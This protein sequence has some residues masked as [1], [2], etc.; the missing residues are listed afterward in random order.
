[1]RR[2]ILEFIA[3]WISP[4]VTRINVMRY[5]FAGQKPWG[6][7]YFVFRQRVI[8]NNLYSE[9][10]LN[11]FKN[12][13]GFA[14]YGAGLDERVVEYPWLFSHFSSE[15]KK[16]LDAG[17]TFNF[18][19]IL[20]HPLLEE[21]DI[22]IFTLA[23]ERQCFWY[24]GVS[25]HYG[26]LRKMPFQ[27]SWFDEVVCIS[28]LEHVGMD[29]RNYGGGTSELEQMDFVM[30]VNELIRVL[31]PGGNIYITVP[32]GQLQYVKWGDT[33]FM[34]QFNASL[35]NQLVD[36]QPNVTFDVTYYQYDA[37]GWR[38]SNSASADDAT[39]FNIHE[40]KEIDADRAAAARAIACLVGK[41]SED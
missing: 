40:A 9:K 22:T 17:S 6:P 16:L 21:R 4:I 29:N 23:P 41:K 12:N 28:T 11:Q 27:S 35:L 26:D 1:M 18:S 8:K 36:S 5:Q 38:L 34:Q 37:N 31:K 30:A 32:Y 20:D 2:K 13:Q 39:Y 15:K 10:L 7:G 33:I 24:K 3:G 14:P 25:Y 19:I